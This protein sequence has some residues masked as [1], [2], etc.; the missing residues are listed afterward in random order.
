MHFTFANLLSPGVKVVSYGAVSYAVQGGSNVLS[1]WMKSSSVIIPK[2][3][4]SRLNVRRYVLYNWP[5]HFPEV[6]YITLYKML[7][8]IEKSGKSFNKV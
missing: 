4:L 7:P 8:K 5:L 3:L 2:K 1:L 6:L